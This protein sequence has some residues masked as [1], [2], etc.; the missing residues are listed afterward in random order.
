MKDIKEIRKVKE[1]KE[2]AQGRQGRQGNQGEGQGHLEG[3]LI[4]KLAEVGGR[5]ALE[6]GG[7]GA[8]GERLAALEQTVQQLVHFIGQELRPDLSRSALQGSSQAA[9]DEKDLKDAEKGSEIVSLLP[10]PAILA[11]ARTRCW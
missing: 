8:I 2:K 5:S 11:P 7:S 6:H 9:K 1:V 3:K 4:E 10:A